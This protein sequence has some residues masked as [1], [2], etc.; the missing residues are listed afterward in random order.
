MECD[1]FFYETYRKEREI[2]ASYTESQFE[3][4]NKVLLK[5]IISHNIIIIN[6]SRY[7]YPS[8]K[9]KQQYFRRKHR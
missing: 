5:K 7:L 3:S 2:F 8:S 6:L 1:A 9:I 4:K